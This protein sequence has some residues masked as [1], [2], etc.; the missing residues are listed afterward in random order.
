MP[1]YRARSASRK[2]LF[3]TGAHDPV[4]YCFSAV[5]SLCKLSLILDRENGR[6]TAASSSTYGR[7]AALLGRS[8]SDVETPRR[9][10]PAKDLSSE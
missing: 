9:A 4:S 5:A 3:L 1:Q 8:R 2:Y 10:L 6:A 7:S